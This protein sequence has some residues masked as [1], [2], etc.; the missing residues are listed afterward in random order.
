MDDFNCFSLVISFAAIAT[1]IGFGVLLYAKT[2]T[3]Q[4]KIRHLEHDL[5]ELG[6]AHAHLLSTVTKL[7]PQ[8]LLEQDATSSTRTPE[9]IQATDSEEEDNLVTH[10]ETVEHNA[11]SSDDPIPPPPAVHED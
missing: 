1:A 3:L 4:H 2:T 7:S 9:P 5:A 10:A 6:S 11:P 8:G